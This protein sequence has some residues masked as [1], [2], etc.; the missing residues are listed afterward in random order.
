M[1]IQTHLQGFLKRIMQI[2]ALLISSIVKEV[3]NEI[4]SLRVIRNAEDDINDC[5]YT[6]KSLTELLKNKEREQCKKL[7]MN[8][9]ENLYSKVHAIRNY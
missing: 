8:L 9:L 6:E 7:L 2:I 4:Y 3:L 5:W 1:K